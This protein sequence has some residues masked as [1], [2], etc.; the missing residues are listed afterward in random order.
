MSERY[1][2]LKQALKFTAAGV[3]Q[4]YNHNRDFI[5]EAIQIAR[6]EISMIPER[7]HLRTL[8]EYYDSILHGIRGDKS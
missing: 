2:V 7:Q 4:S 6:G 5:K 8:Y 1:R 3:E